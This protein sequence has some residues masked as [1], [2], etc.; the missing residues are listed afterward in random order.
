MSKKL[1][2]MNLKKTT[3]KSTRLSIFDRIVREIDAV[4][5]PTRYIEQII[6]QYYDGGVTEIYPDD[7]SLPESINKDNTKA[8]LE[9]SGNEIKDL[10]IFINTERLEKDVNEELE[11]ILGKYC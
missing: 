3:K 7:I 1:P 10:R 11:K 2:D 8:A 9:T 4:E 5:I 6:V